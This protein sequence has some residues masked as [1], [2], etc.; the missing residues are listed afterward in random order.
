MII[1]EYLKM[2]NLSVRDTRALCLLLIVIGLCLGIAD[3]REV[4]SL[5]IDNLKKIRQS[6]DSVYYFVVVNMEIKS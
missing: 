3:S 6:M 2:M 5:T 4:S 1:Y